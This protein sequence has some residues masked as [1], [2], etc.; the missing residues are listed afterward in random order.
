MSI[1]IGFTIIGI[2]TGL[3]AGIL[4]GGA[5]ILIVPLL[6]LFGLLGT[7]KHRIATSLYMLLPPIGIFAAYNF[8]KHG[9]GHFWPAMYMALLFTLFSFI[10]SYYFVNIKNEEKMIGLHIFFGAFTILAG[11]YMCAKPFVNSNGTG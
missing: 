4:G 5:E 7:V 3:F 2:I 11:I 1:W 6:T 10:S 8:Y 9:Y